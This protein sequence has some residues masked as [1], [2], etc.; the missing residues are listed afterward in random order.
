MRTAGD[1]VNGSDG[2]GGVGM[3]VRFFLTRCMTVGV[4]VIMNM[5]IAIMRV[6]MLVKMGT[7]ALPETPNSNADQHDTDKA[8]TPGGDCF[9]RDQFPK[10]EC[11]KT[12][13]QNAA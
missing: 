4:H 6:G 12:D 8:F 3:L 7:E 5:G 10:K 13:K 1:A 2:K 9:N 11:E